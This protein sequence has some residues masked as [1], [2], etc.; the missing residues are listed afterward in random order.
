MTV[1]KAAR[2]QEIRRMLE[3]ERKKFVRYQDMQRL[4]SR[5]ALERF[6]YRL[7]ASPHAGKFVLKGA[8]LLAI[9][10]P[11]E[12]RST[13]DGDLLAHGRYTRQS[14]LGMLQT[15]CAIKQ[16]DG[17]TFRP[18]KIDARDAGTT[19]EYPGFVA[20]IPAMLGASNCDIHLDIGFGEAVTPA[21]ATVAF[22]SLL[23]LPRPK[24]KVYPLETVIAEKFHAIVHLGMSNT[25][26]KDY[27]D[28]AEIARSCQLDGATV[29]LA[30]EATFE[31]RRTHVPGET[32]AGLTSAF[33]DAKG[34]QADWKAFLRRHG[35]S[36]S[37][38]LETA[39]NR[40]EALVMPPAVACALGQAFGPV[41]R[42]E[43]WSEA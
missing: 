2:A 40:I 33:Y 31:H 8:L 26:L 4:L 28:L 20:I 16:D 11:D 19:R 29:R 23:K 22:P 17:L 5:Y 9:Y 13:R 32:P 12:Y 25:R 18:G 34:K 24:L 35:L 37:G 1:D 3:A 41:W 6:L 30:I 39:C 15:I 42:N 7:G 14:L 27:Y 43:A 36:K 38:D 10:L 21:P